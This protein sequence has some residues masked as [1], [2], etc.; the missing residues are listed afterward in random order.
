MFVVQE[1]DLLTPVSWFRQ[2]KEEDKEESEGNVE[3]H[4]HLSDTEDF[5]LSKDG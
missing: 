2:K 5:L 3:L 1:T 4:H